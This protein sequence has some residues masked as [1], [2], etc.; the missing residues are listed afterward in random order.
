M[1]LK[2]LVASVVGSASDNQWGQVLMTPGAYGVIE[3]EDS[4]G[5]AR[6]IGIH[7]LSRLTQ[8]LVVPPA[9][10]TDLIKVVDENFN[11]QI[12]TLVLLVPIDNVLYVVLRGEGAVYLKRGEKLAQLL[13]KPGE[14]SG[15]AR[16]GDTLI[17][18]SSSFIKTLTPNE[19][20]GVFDHATPIEVAE[21]LTLSL[22]EKNSSPGCVALIFQV[23][24]FL[25]SEETVAVAQP[26]LKHHNSIFRRIRER[27]LPTISGI[28]RRL[29]RLLHRPKILLAA[30]S[31]LLLLFFVISVILGLQKQFGNRQNQVI[32]SAISE[33]QRTYE[34][35]LA[36]GDLNAIKGREKLAQANK[37]IE[38]W[39]K[40]STR[41]PDGYKIS[42]LT[43]QIDEAMELAMQINRG[44]PQL[45]FDVALLKSGSHITN[46]AG[47]GNN[48]ALLDSDT[49]TVYGLDISSKEA[50]IAAGG[51]DFTNSNAI[52]VHGDK[53]YVLTN[54]GINQIRISDK[55]TT[56][57]I[58]KADKDWGK[59]T[60]LVAYGGNLYLLDTQHNRIWKY[61]AID[62]APFFSELREY[63]NPDTLPDFSKAGNM[64]IDGSVWLGGSEGKIWKFTSG[65]ETTFQPQGVEPQFGSALVVYV[66]DVDKYAYVLDQQNKRVV[67]LDKDG[68]YLAQYVWESD[69]VATD[70]IV[71]ENSK[72]IL[73]LGDGKIYSLE[74]K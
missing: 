31:L 3:I 49:K 47:E 35:G 61:V 9:S 36:L 73:L 71:S 69:L 42:V 5:A 62:K 25:E 6:E 45:F 2:P 13:V 44:E 38:P 4:N 74:L 70:I 39:Q 24:N 58:I 14:I 59:I 51:D 65:Q 34:E 15:E 11:F 28:K 18:A 8:K 21:K 56:V 7:L 29:L 68:L 60:S 16:V 27:R 22:H 10:L 50:V 1:R 63:L 52:S 53:I 41:T 46:F 64:I 57:N 40:L 54:L 20:E 37:I 23:E 32:A 67:V 72:K 66:S 33:A 30:V 19:I 12:V 17:L 55:K 48:L 43:K 26:E